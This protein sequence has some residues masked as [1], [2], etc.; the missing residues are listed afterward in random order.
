MKNSLTK[1]FVTFFSLVLLSLPIV[2]QVGK[3]ANQSQDRLIKS[4]VET[5]NSMLQAIFKKHK[6]GEMSLEQAKKL[7][8]DLL[9]E[10]RYG[11]DGYFWADT[12]EGV[13]V[14]LYGRK[15]VEGKNRLEA[16]DEHGTSFIKE[17]ISAGKN[18]GGYVEYWFTKKGKSSPEA[19]R[20]Y[21]L[22]FQPFGWVVGTGYYR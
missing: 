10:L 22:L 20:S 7:G 19:K 4:E 18:G 8:A 6:L 5:A 21:A 15:D 17:L 14:V 3:L 9:R 12:E 2:A 11:E 1:V 16:K 13:N